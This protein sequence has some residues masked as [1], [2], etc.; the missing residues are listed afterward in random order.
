MI[1]HT[2]S[3]K[4][5]PIKWIFYHF[6]VKIK[7]F[8]DGPYYGL[9][10]SILIRESDQ[11][12][13]IQIIQILQTSCSL[14]CSC[15]AWC[16][17]ENHAAVVIY[18]YMYVFACQILRHRYHWFQSNKLKTNEIYFPF[19]LDLAVSTALPSEPSHLI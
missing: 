14:N 6:Y 4:F 15:T 7:T 16:S 2:F 11:S 12:S 3:K 1:L 13:T 18:C 19:F 5:P 9:Q 8:K 17:N 10:V